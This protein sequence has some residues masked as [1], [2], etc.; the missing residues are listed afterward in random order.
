MFHSNVNILLGDNASGKTRYLFSKV[1]T[2]SQ[3]GV[4]LYNLNNDYTN[5]NLLR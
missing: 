5:N 4:V 1:Q 2:L 3:N